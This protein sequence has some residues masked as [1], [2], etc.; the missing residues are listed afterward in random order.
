MYNYITASLLCFV[1]VCLAT[2]DTV[3]ADGID[4]ITYVTV[5][6]TAFAQPYLWN[7][8]N[9]KGHLLGHFDSITVYLITA[10]EVYAGTYT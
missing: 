1:V 6:V 7:C 8:C 2:A 3:L 4:V 5:D 10:S 9:R